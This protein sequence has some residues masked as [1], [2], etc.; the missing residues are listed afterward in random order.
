MRSDYS[1]EM[2]G[3]WL[4]Q[5]DLLVSLA[6]SPRTS[7]HHLEFGHDDRHGSCRAAPRARGGRPSDGLTWALVKADLEGA[8]SALEAAL[9][10]AERNTRYDLTLVTA[11]PSWLIV[12]RI[13]N[14]AAPGNRTI[15]HAPDCP[16]ALLAQAD[17]GEAAPA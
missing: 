1:P 16:F 4:A 17:S 13:C 7:V 12:C 14:Q 11:P 6:E 2:I 10:M 3:Y 15:N 5:W 9:E 8:A